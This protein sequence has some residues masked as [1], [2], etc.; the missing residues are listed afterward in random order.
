MIKI[1]TISPCNSPHQKRQRNRDQLVA[2]H[3]EGMANKVEDK[4]TRRR[5][6]VGKIKELAD[7]PNQ[8]CV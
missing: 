4:R 5:E 3:G 7:L 8:N 1:T 2:I 6:G